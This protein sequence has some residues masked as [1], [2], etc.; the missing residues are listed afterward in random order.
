MQGLK[1]VKYAKD[2]LSR[3]YLPHGPCSLN[4]NQLSAAN[5]WLALGTALWPFSNVLVFK[6]VLLLGGKKNILG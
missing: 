1:E 6:L 3:A 4:G 5:D 2:M